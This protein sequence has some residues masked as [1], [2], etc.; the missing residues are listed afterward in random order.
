MSAMQEHDETME[1]VETRIGSESFE[2][3]TFDEKGAQ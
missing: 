1:S 2:I 3:A